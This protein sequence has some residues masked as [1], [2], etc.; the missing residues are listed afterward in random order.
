[1]P[2]RRLRQILMDRR[3]AT[4]MQIQTLD[5]PAITGPPAMQ[6]HVLRNPPLNARA[7]AIRVQAPMKPA[8]K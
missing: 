8:I 2:I 3:R 5:F 1:V 6:V 7:I 4:K